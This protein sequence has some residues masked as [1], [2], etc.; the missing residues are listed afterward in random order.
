MEKQER[1]RFGFG[2]KLIYGLNS[3]GGGLLMGTIG[4]Y[5]MIYFTDSALLNVAFVGTL[6]FV[7]K[8]FNAFFS[9]VVGVIIDKAHTR[10]GKVKPFMF[11]GSILVAILS[12]LMFSAAGIPGVTQKYIYCAVIYFLFNV[13][14][15]FYGTANGSVFPTLTRDVEERK[16]LAIVP[17]IGGV[18]G[19][20][21]NVGAVFPLL[22][23]V[24]ATEAQGFFRLVFAFSAIY[25][26]FNMIFLN[27]YQEKVTAKNEKITLKQMLR[28]LG[29]NDQ[30]FVI[31]IVQFLFNVGVFITTGMA[32]YF[33]KYNVGNEDMYAVF[34]I[35]VGLFQVLVMALF[36][37]MMKKLTKKLAYQL[38][39]LSLIL[40]YVILFLSRSIVSSFLPIVIFCGLLLYF[41][42]GISGSIGSIF[43]AD[44]IDYGEWKTKERNNSVV[45]S[46]FGLFG[47]LADA[48]KELIVGLTMTAIGFTPVFPQPQGVLT[49]LV[50][51]MTGI[52]LILLV[53]TL[54]V[55]TRFYKLNDK[56]Y[57]RINEELKERIQEKTSK[58]AD[59]AE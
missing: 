34:G 9:P 56:Y 50:F 24:A 21:T 42:L 48:T 25:F 22:S 2:F 57:N 3:Y 13:S 29:Q 49:G 7:G 45:V 38:G 53:I 19:D 40:G 5:L 58:E 39:V 52:P 36:P 12:V 16:K 32:I 6:F 17:A 8:V 10:W 55:F 54:I 18:L 26:V 14:S 51:I 46:I 41:G 30:L 4:S 33:F 47:T 1:N 15:N 35:T 37:K 43:T 28:A 20:F 44:V 27:R 23:V 11:V 31:L 59:R